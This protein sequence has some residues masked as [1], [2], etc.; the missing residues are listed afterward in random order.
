MAYVPLRKVV[1]GYGRYSR[2]AGPKS[3]LG[4]RNGPTRPFRQTLSR[5][6]FLR[7]AINPSVTNVLIP[8]LRQW[9]F[10]CCEKCL[11]RVVAIQL[12]WLLDVTS[13][14]PERSEQRSDV[15]ELEHLKS[16]QLGGVWGE[17]ALVAT[18]LGCVVEEVQKWR[19][20]SSQLRLG[21]V[22]LVESVG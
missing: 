22:G 17:V 18:L 1:G 3:M 14:E 6:L 20:W 4:G 12:W 10:A 13:D 11:I 21:V 9:R 7:P 5:S 8:F 2:H 19:R 16:R 15:G